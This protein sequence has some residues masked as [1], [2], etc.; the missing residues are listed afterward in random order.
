MKNSI[1][2]SHVINNSQITDTDNQQYPDLGATI[3]PISDKMVGLHDYN[4]NKITVAA[5]NLVAPMILDYLDRNKYNNAPIHLSVASL[6]T[7]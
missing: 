5:R 7:L 1:T 3:V 6:P 4:R 2:N